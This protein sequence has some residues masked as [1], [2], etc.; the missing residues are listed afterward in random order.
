MSNA[1]YLPEPPRVWSRV[2]N[3][4]TYINA[5]D[6]YAKVINGLQTL[7]QANYQEKLLYKGNILK[8]KGNSAQLTKK[9]KYT[10][11]AKGFG[12]NRTKVFA[13]QSETYSNP[14]TTGLL[15]V[16]GIEIPYPN[17][18]VGQPNNPSGPYKSNVANPDN[19]NN[20]GSLLDGGT[21]VYGTYV[22][23]CSQEIVRICRQRGDLIC[24]PSTASDV[25]GYP[26]ALCWDPAL[27]TWFPKPRYF[28]NNSTDKWPEGYKGFV[29]AVT[30][31]P[32]TIISLVNLVLSWKY[33]QNCEVPI[34]SFH[35]Y[36][37]SVFFTSVNYTT[38]SYTFNSLNVNDTIY[39]T[40]VSTNIESE[41]S[42]KVVFV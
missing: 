40:S 28:M 23:P 13:T 25:P 16:G 17:Y 32:P 11:L 7:E 30:P 10:Q 8:Y 19:C 36:V 42:N 3:K 2:Q 1:N 6:D 26:I 31:E 29:S 33:I 24:N 15:R 20:N 39:M 34:S 9:Q 41:P 27:Q 4:C 38:T 14:N 18:L 12:P 21:L 22:N 37:N 5:N 35:I